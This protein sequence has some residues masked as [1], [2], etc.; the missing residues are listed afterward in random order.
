MKMKG[1][2]GRQEAQEPAKGHPH[3]GRQR[4]TKGDMVPRNPAMLTRMPAIP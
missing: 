4:E 1:D 3:E 2:K